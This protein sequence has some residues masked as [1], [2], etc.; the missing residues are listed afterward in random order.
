MNK[1]DLI[2]RLT[3]DPELRYNS[4]NVAYSRFTLAVN[5]SFLNANGERE[6]D[7]ISCVAWRKTAE[8]INKHFKKGSE[9]GLSGRIQTGSYEKENG[10][11]AYTTDIIIEE[12][13]FIGSKK[14]SRPAPEYTGPV[15]ETANEEATS[16][17]NLSYENLDKE[18]RL[19]D[20]DLPF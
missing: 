17:E 15:D 18:V 13:T 6:A 20:S 3:A 14:D 9:V 4:N 2:G 16:D 10:D 8:L 12:I 7:F 11:K 5:R 19:E 1:V